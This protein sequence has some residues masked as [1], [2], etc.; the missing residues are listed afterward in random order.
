MEGEGERG[1]HGGS[2]RLL[3]GVGIE[4][5]LSFW[6][7]WWEANFEEGMEY[8]DVVWWLGLRWHGLF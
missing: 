1:M 4:R 2:R 7:F 6:F 3:W 8:D 5:F